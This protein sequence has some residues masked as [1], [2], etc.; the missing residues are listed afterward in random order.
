MKPTSPLALC[1]SL[2]LWIPLPAQQNAHSHG[3]GAFDDRESSPCL[4]DEDRAAIIQLLN[5]NLLLLQSQGYAV[6]QNNNERASVSFDWP[7][8][9]APGLDFNS[10]YGINNFVDHDPSTALLDYHCDGRTYDGH[11]GIDIDTWPFP[12]YLYDN[13]LVEVIA[14]E[15]GTIL[16]KQD[17]FEDDHCSCLGTWN[18]IYVQHADGS[19]AWYGHMKKNSLTLKGV[20]QTVA[21]GEYLG[22]VASSGCS[23]GP[24]L[25]LEVYNSANYSLSNLRDPYQGECNEYNPDSWWANQKPNREP[26]VNALL[27]HDEEPVHGCP[28]INESPHFQNTFVPGDQIYTAAYYHDQLQGS[29]SNFR[30]RRPDYTIWKNWSHS[31]PNTY[32]HSWWWW[33]WYLP[34]NGPFGTWTVEIDYNGTTLSH[35]FDYQ[36]ETATVEEAGLSVEIY[37]NP[38]GAWVQISG[39]ERK[40]ATLQVLDRLGRTVLVPKLIPGQKVELGELP[41]GLYFFRIQIPEGVILKRAIKI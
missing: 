41:P 25:H 31:A 20:G 10:Y 23:T 11:K 14:A 39:L 38:A 7:V 35:G 15:A 28:G 21:K 1:I 30:I 32:N 19:V 6:P 13:N 18:A 2:F 3:G 8:R 16:A 26:T 36:L 9:K 34:G 12:W 27:T 5:D 4:T 24:H 37:P 22:V 29:I 17:G 33:S 40:V